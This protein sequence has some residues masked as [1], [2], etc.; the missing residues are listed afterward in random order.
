MS[1]T[2]R[3]IIIAVVIL[4]ILG[5]IGKKQGW[6]GGNSAITVDT[7]FAARRTIIE[8]VSASGKIQP[9]KEVKL[10]PEV[11][12]E[13]VD[14]PVV[15]GQR[16][17]KGELLV[18][19]NPDLIEAAVDRAEASLNQS[20][21]NLSSSKAQLVEAENNYNRNEPL[22]KK[23]VISTAQWD[24]IVRA[25]EVAKLNVESAEAMVKNGQASLKEA[26][27]NLARTTIYAPD[28]G[29]ISALYVELGERVVGTNQMQGTE[30]MRIANLNNMEVVVNVNETDIVRVETGDSV[31]VEVDAYLDKKFKGVV[32]EI[33]SSAELQNVSA[34]QVT[35]FE[36]KIRI[37]RE[38]YLDLEKDGKSPF[39]PGMTATVDIITEVAKE[40]LC[41]PIQ[42]VTTRSDTSS[43]AT[44]LSNRFGDSEE[45]YEVIF[46]YEE[47][48]AMLQAVETGVQDDKYIEI[49]EGL[50]DSTEIITGPY[51]TVSQELLNQDI[52]EK[53]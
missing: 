51:R 31:D 14:L 42:A 36:V 8:T 19:I 7:D 49:L 22:H 18:R 43:E 40:V 46:K 34:D 48:K 13:I 32:T 16:V 30:L 41:V 15:E 3:Y 53:K 28:S 10:A 23:G 24:Q 11:S 2:V 20:K 29:T 12:G 50:E 35:N 38:S 37:L 6:F 27:D 9:E 33:A 21:A 44:R 45:R 4:M 1:K 5:I 39:R 17:S 47:G 25:Y 52:V 26:R